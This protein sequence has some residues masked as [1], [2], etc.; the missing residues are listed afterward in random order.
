[1]AKLP[2]ITSRAKNAPAMGALKTAAIPP[3]TPHPV[4]MGKRL[5]VTRSTCPSRD[6]REAPIWTMGPSRPT[7]PPV[8]IVKAEVSA[9]MSAPC[10][11]NFPLL[12]ATDSMTS[13]TPCPR[14]S[15]A[16]KTTSATKSP[17]SA[18]S[19]R[20]W[21]QA[22]CGRIY[23]GRSVDPIAT[24]WTALIISAKRIAPPPVTSPT[25]HAKNTSEKGWTA[26]IGCGSVYREC[27][28]KQSR[29]VIFSLGG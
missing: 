7:E 29:A 16:K 14:S 24:H 15:R 25:A 17:P 1:M 26:L 2:I 4:S 18:G 20:T 6:P 27:E 19:N 13:G 28:G 8:P 12:R 22:R 10:G 3:A 21:Y 11:R 9:M 5:G 23:N